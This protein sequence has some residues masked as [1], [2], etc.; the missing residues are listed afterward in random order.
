MT[1]QTYNN[2]YARI[3]ELIRK[4]QSGNFNQ[5]TFPAFRMGL[6]SDLEDLKI[7]AVREWTQSKHFTHSEK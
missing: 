2:I 6:D 3:K 1:D 4:V 7:E 5:A